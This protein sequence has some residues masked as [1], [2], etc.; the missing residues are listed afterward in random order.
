[1]SAPTLDIFALRDSVVD[2]YKR[3]ATSF[4]AIHAPDIRAQVEASCAEERCWSGPRVRIHRALVE[5]RDRKAH[6]ERCARP[7]MPQCCDALPRAG[8]TGPPCFSPLGPRKRAG[9]A[10]A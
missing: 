5:R 9:A 3:F 8:A 2:E 1:M 7:V 6:G 10:D 4:T